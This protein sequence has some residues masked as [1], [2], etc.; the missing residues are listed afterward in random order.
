MTITPIRLGEVWIERPV[1]DFYRGWKEVLWAPM[2]SWII[3]DGT[4]ISLVDCG[5][6]DAAWCGEHTRKVRQ[7]PDDS[8]STSLAR[9]GLRPTDVRNLVLTHLHWDHSGVL[10]LFPESNIILQERELRYAMDPVW[11]HDRAFWLEE[12]GA[13]RAIGDGR[14]TMVNGDARISA[15]VEVSI[16]PGHTPGS[17]IVAVGNGSSRIII[18]GDTI[19]LLSSI[20]DSGAPD[21]Y[22]PGGVYVDLQEYVETLDKLRGIGAPILPGHEPSLARDVVIRP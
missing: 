17:Q 2:W 18:A 5:P 13:N 8:I 11:V 20:E 22:R 19:S 3:R 10:D 9:H 1:L 14:M 16:A 6:P 12:T 4:D 21:H 7:M 15:S